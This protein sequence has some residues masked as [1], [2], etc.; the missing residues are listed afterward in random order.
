MMLLA[1]LIPALIA[2]ITISYTSKSKNKVQTIKVPIDKRK[3]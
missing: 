2:F 1:L 3:F